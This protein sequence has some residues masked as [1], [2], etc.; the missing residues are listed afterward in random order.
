MIHLLIYNPPTMSQILLEVH[1]IEKQ[2][3]FHPKDSFLAG[4]P[5]GGCYSL[6]HSLIDCFT[7]VR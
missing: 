5:K 7:S 4:T 1:S 3:L 2:S 6:R